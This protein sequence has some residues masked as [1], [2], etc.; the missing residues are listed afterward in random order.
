GE[1]IGGSSDRVIGASPGR[2]PHRW[3]LRSRG[4]AG[5][6]RHARKRPA[7]PVLFARAPALFARPSALGARTPELFSPA[8]VL[9]SPMIALFARTS[10]FGARAFEL[11]GSDLVLWSLKASQRGR[12]TSYEHID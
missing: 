7:E 2:R 4:G 5:Y 9:F 8:T 10:V 1:G 6:V 11:E 3:G 12:F